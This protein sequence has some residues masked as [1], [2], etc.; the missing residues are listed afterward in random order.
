MLAGDL[1]AAD[2]AQKTRPNVVYILADDQGYGDAQSFNPG[3]LIPTPGID[4]LAREGMRFTDAHSASAVCTPTRYGLLTGRYSWRTRLQSGVLK[5]GTDPLID[6]A[7][8]TV[9]GLFKQH[10]YKTA[11]VGKWHL[12]FHYDLPEGTEM[13][14]P[15]GERGAAPVGSRVLGGPVARDFDEF[16]GF[17]HAREMRTWIEQDTVVANLESS[18]EMLP[19]IGARSIQYIR[20]QGDRQD[21]PF[22]LYVPLSAPHGPIVPTKEWQGRSGLGAYADFVMQT[23]D[24]VGR[25]LDTLDEVG[26][27]DDTMV[28]FATDNGTAPVAKID[29]LR[30]Q[31]HDP[32]GGLRGHKA[33]AWDG[34]H[35]VPFVVRWPGVVT[36]DSICN[37]TI[38]LNSLLATCAD[39][40]QSRL[41]DSA[42][43]DSFSIMPLLQ[44][45]QAETPT[46]PYVI[47]HSIKGHFAIR[48]GKWKFVAC[49]GSGGWSKGD[50]GQPAQLYDMAADRAE[51]NNLLELETGV[52][53]DLA[54]LL[55][56][57]VAQ[58]RTRPGPAQAN[59]VAVDIWKT[60][61]GRPRVL[62]G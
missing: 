21:Q 34:G 29:A 48:R 59:D 62:R 30:K 46:H 44:G 38:C 24:V 35:R 50:D 8:L 55:E 27:A 47:H 11:C 53:R 9:Q 15:K 49:K 41:P 61:E 18:E 36:Q 20:Q 39:L 37:E 42:G 13:I 52:A 54:D 2:R 3:G 28:F 1:L 60:E 57:A 19:M 40:V 16:A 25:I 6:P 33:D 51:K 22:F 58:G 31:G 26:L 45:R 32:L 12:G 4:R 10:G 56:R 23:D 7:T 17:H 43:V 5:T 14:F